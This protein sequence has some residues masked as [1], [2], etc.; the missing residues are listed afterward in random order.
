M[1]QVKILIL[2]V[3]GMMAF[4]ATATTTA[5]LEEKQKTV[6]YPEV[7]FTIDAVSVVNDFQIFNVNAFQSFEYHGLPIKA[8]KELKTV[9]FIV[10][11]V[12]FSSLGL[13]YTS[14]HYKEKLLHNYSIAFI[15]NLRNQNFRIRSDC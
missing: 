8:T 9:A 1:K 15:H 3:I 13:S 11:D 7:T 2:S 4:T 14:I 12:G 6:F 5:K 10:E